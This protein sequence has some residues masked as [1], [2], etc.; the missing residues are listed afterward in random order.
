MDVSLSTIKDRIPEALVYASVNWASH[1]A[2]VK[3]R[4]GS[5]QR[6]LGCTVQTL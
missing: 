4:G 5:G 2:N 1:V 3:S 6:S